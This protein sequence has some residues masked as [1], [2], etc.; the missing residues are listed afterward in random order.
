MGKSNTIF[1]DRKDFCRKAGGY[2]M[3]YIMTYY[4]ALAMSTRLRQ[5]DVINGSEGMILIGLGAYLAYVPSGSVL[6][7]G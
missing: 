6:F 5:N 2:I 3:L 4:L 7:D 1:F